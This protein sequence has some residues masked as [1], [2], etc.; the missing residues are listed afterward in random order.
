MSE[1]KAALERSGFSVPRLSRSRIS[2]IVLREALAQ[3]WARETSA[4]PGGWSSSNPAWGQ[5]AVT[6]LIVQDMFGGELLRC[7]VDSTSHYWNR[8][9]SGEE[10]DLTRHQF[11]SDFRPSRPELRTR[12]YVI[13]F[14]DTAARYGRL[15]KSVQ[16][17]L[18]RLTRPA[19][20]DHV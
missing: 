6:A 19:Q 7:K 10:L 5:C 18:R 1:S 11:G 16:A 17:S 4:D 14:P 2:R 20:T 9:P 13:G 3:A 8:L 12:T 15:S